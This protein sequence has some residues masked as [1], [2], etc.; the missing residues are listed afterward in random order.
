MLMSHLAGV[1]AGQS[2]GSHCCA[3]GQMGVAPTAFLYRMSVSLMNKH[4]PTH[5]PH[6][7]TPAHAGLCYG[8][9]SLDSKCLP[10]SIL[11]SCC[12][13]QGVA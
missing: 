7:P 11:A 1:R 9:D 6:P 13:L 10:Y 8:S 4:T 3:H 12:G 5:N 2:T